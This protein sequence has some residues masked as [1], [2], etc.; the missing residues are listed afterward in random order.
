MLIK[1]SVKLLRV[2]FF[3]VFALSAIILLY[4][5]VYCVCVVMLLFEDIKN[6]LF[7]VFMEI[8]SMVCDVFVSFDECC[9]VWV[10]KKF[11]GGDVECGVVNVLF[12]VLCV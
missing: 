10:L 2:A 12:Y 5:C 3:V 4:C 1:L 6:V 8:E 9:F 11:F 7:D